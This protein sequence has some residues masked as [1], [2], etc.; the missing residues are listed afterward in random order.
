MIGKLGG[1]KAAACL[2]GLG[3]VVGCY[4]AKG[5]VPGEVTE[6]VKYLVTLYLGGNIAADVVANVTAVKSKAVDAQQAVTSATVVDGA[7]TSAKM[8]Q[9][10]LSGV[11][12]QIDDLNVQVETLT[13]TVKTQDQ[14][15]QQ[16]VGVITSST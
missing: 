15:L 11:Q 12:S 4:L 13:Q 6:M 5:A 10:D 14:T 9:V 2:I 1:R 3:A 16:V 8:A 7:V